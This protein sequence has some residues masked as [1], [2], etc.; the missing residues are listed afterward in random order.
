[1]CRYIAGTNDT[2]QMLPVRDLLV[3]KF[4]EKASHMDR[5]TPV[6]DLQ[7]TVAQH[8]EHLGIQHRGE[9]IE[10]RVH[11]G[12]DAEQCNFFIAQLF[13]FHFVIR[14]HVTHL[15]NVEGSQRRTTR[16]QDRF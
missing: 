4:I 10:G 3:R 15:L 9:K 14:H 11:I 12:H 2:D 7:C 13:Q 16:N 5:Q 8:I 1:M 6:I